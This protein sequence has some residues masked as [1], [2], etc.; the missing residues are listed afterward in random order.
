VIFG[1]EFRIDIGPHHQQAGA[2]RLG[3]GSLP[4][5]PG[6]LTPRRRTR[7]GRR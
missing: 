5:L 2:A 7:R 4:S 3:H 6:H 1:L